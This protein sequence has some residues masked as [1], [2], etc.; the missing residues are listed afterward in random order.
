[1]DPD[2]WEFANEDFLRGQRFLLKNIHRR[3]PPGNSQAANTAQNAAS[4]NMVRLL[5]RIALLSRYF[6]ELTK[7]CSL[8]GA[9]LFWSL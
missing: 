3:K 6:L 7:D 2:R 5:P 1:M 8:G 9:L 4:N